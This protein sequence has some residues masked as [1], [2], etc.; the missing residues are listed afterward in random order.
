MGDC[1]YCKSLTIDSQQKPFTAYQED[2][3]EVDSND[4]IKVLFAHVQEVSALHNASICYQQINGAICLNSPVHQGIHL[5][6]VGD[7]TVG[8]R[9]ND[10]L[11]LQLRSCPA[12]AGA[13]SQS[14]IAYAVESEPL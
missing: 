5:S 8:C 12:D 11:K 10:A 13:V 3:F 1:V 2:S 6:L 9:G 14:C 4:I 7:I